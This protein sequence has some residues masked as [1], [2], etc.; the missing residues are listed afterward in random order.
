VVAFDKTGT[1]TE[2]K[3][4]LVTVQPTRDFTE[5]ELLRLA[6]ALE[7]G[8]EHPLAAAILKGAR[9]RVIDPPTVE[10]FESVGATGSTVSARGIEQYEAAA[11]AIAK[12]VTGDP[13]LFA[14]VATCAPKGP[15]DVA[16][17]R[18]MLAR[19]GERA[20]RRPLTEPELVKLIG[21]VGS[22]AKTLG[23]F[24]KGAFYGISA[25]L[26][27]PYFLYRPVVG[28]PDP[29]N[30]GLFLVDEPGRFVIL[31]DDALIENF[32][33]AVLRDG[34]PVGYRVSTTAYD[35]EPQSLVMSGSFATTG[36]LG[37]AITLDAEAPT[38]PFRHKYHPDHNNLNNLYTEFREEAYPVSRTLSFEFSS[39]DPSDSGGASFG[40]NQMGGTYHETI[41]GLHRNDIAVEGIFTLDRISVS[42][43]LNE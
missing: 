23:S 34:Q 2:G 11:Q 25:I 27:S 10:G 30:P 24:E 38:N 28:E 3:P 40:S 16:C 17:A 35:F 41:S 19:L 9:D 20:Y 15:D 14:R 22:A 5:I 33:G 6:A 13:K 18:A 37:A 31:T 43:V 4:R 21:A 12:Q 36:V 8:S 7:K 42:P 39:T 32:T 26:Q 29:E 1:L